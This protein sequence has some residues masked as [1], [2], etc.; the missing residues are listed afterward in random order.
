MDIAVIVM[1]CL[2]LLVLNAIGVT[3]EV[4]EFYF[5]LNL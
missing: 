5:L 1:I 2:Y 3:A 4:D